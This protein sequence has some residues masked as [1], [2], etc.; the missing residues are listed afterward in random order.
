MTISPIDES[1]RRAAI[2]AGISYLITLALVF[3]ANFAIQH[4]LVV[5][6]NPGATAQNILAH[7]QLLRGQFNNP[8]GIALD[9]AGNLYVADSQNHR[10]QKLVRK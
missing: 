1:Q 7:Q 3:Y 5:A 8:W 6:N 4:P 9:S 2:V 10:V